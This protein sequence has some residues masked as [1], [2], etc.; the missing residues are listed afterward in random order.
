M[1]NNKDIKIGVIGLGAQGLVAVKNLLEEGFDVTGFEKNDFVGGIW[2][3]SAETRVSV[4]PTTIVNSSKRRACFTDFPFPDE[5][6]SYPTSI[7]VDKYLNAY[8]HYFSLEPH[9]R[10]GT[11]IEHVSRN[12]KEEKWIVHA[13]PNGSNNV[14]EYSFDKLVVALGPNSKPVEP[15]IHDRHKFKGEILH[16][17]AFR[18]HLP[19]KNKRVMVVGASNTAADTCT[20]L[21]GIASKI[22][23]SHRNPSLVVPRYLKN[24]TILDHGLN[25]R[26]VQAT[27]FIEHYLPGVST[28]FMQYMVSKLVQGEYGALDPAWNLSPAPSI[29]HKVPTVSDYLIPYLRDG[30][31]ISTASPGRI[32]DDYDVELEDGKVV[33]VDVI[34]FCTGYD[35]DFSVMGKYDP[36]LTSEGTYDHYTP[37][38]YQN[39]LSL[40]HPDSLAYIG[41]AIAFQPAFLT[42]DLSTM[43]LAQLWSTKPASPPFP[44]LAEM[45]AW[46]R[47]HVQWVNSIRATHPTRKMI[48]FS[49]PDGP[50]MKW[51]Q[52]T[53][54]TNLDEN[55]G[56][57]SLKAWKFWW[58]NPRFYYML[59]NGVY[60][61]I[62]YRLFDGDRRKKWDGAREA[63]EK[64]N[65]NVK[66][67]VEIRKAAMKDKEKEYLIRQL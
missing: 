27:Q 6:P 65:A 51:V 29:K 31:V 66:R 46:H 55:L 26:M 12:D 37:R 16:S 8:C 25:Y 36:T 57:T 56:W 43:A 39:I 58:S 61:P 23:F 48:K 49:I 52:D 30:T 1:S 44:A 15:I 2:H 19:F 32:I 59:T 63:I 64:M 21:K 22:Y 47:N 13:R 17:I 35:S 62:F 53:A 9:L 10:L 38:L 40:D 7:K 33:Q 67:D 41:I 4:L 5:T 14:Q 50:W 34:I 3:Y 28:S 24:G 20:I 60:T 18:D 45:Q 42:T 11:A 54:G